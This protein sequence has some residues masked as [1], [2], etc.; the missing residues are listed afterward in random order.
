MCRCPAHDDRTASLRVAEVG[1]KI[2]VRCFAGCSQAAVIDA[3]RHRGL[4]PALHE[5]TIQQKR[6]WLKDRK[7]VERWL[8]DAEAWRYAAVACLEDS[9]DREKGHLLNDGDPTKDLPIGNIYH[10]EEMLSLWKRLENRDLVIEYL[11]QQAENPTQ[12][13][14]CVV[15]GKR[16]HAKTESMLHAFLEIK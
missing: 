4:W 15:A 8:P 2:L 6:D 12:T 14:G 9:L 16:H 3:L 5:F 7:D 13:Q 1:G 10:M 11:V